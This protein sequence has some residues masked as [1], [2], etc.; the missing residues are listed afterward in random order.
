MSTVE[1]HSKNRILIVDDQPGMVE[2]L[3]D[4]LKDRGCTVTLASNGYQALRQVGQQSVD[5]VLMDVVMPGMSGLDTY[6]A[7]KH[8]RPQTPVVM[9]TGHKIDHLVKQ[10]A[11]EG[12]LAVLQKPVDP[13]T[14]V[15]IVLAVLRLAN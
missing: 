7:I 13:A 5:L 14:V 1:R 3:S 10:A 6:R 2:T 8:L 4:I 12:I 9:M 11:Q 15:G